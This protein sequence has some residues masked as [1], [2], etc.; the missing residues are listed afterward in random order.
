MQDGA[1]LQ[2]VPW[3]AKCMTKGPVQE[4]HPGR[5]DSNCQ[6][7]YQGE[8]NGC[9]SA[10]FYFTRKQSHGPRTDGSGRHQQD[11]IDVSL[12]HHR[13]DLVAWEQ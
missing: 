5:L 7:A 12:S 4:E 9:H 6:F 13:A 8:R 2:A 10:G 11:E 3:L 1:L